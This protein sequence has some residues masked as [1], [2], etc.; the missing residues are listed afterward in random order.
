MTSYHK[1]TLL[2]LQLTLFCG[3]QILFPIN[4]FVTIFIEKIQYPAL[5]LSYLNS[6]TPTKSD[7]YLANTL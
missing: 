7:L 3:L 4:D 6:C 1:Q 5:S 2:S